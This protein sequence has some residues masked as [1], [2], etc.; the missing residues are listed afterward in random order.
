M[1]VEVIEK[2]ARKVS[3]VSKRNFLQHTRHT[4]RRLWFILG[5]NLSDTGG[6]CQSLL[7]IVSL[8]ETTCTE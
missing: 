1:A 8:S 6:P 5:D 2:L 4:Q 7:F 3:I